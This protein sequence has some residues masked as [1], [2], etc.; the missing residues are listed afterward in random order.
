MNKYAPA[1]VQTAIAHLEAAVGADTTPSP[2]FKAAQWDPVVK[3]MT[4]GL[5]NAGVQASEF[6]VAQDH[7]VTNAAWRRGALSG[8]LGLLGLI[9]SG[10]LSVLI[11]RRIVRR[12]D[13]LQDSVETLANQELP[14]VVARLRRGE[15]VPVDQMASTTSDLGR[16][17]IGRVG[18]AFDAGRHTEAEAP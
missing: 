2:P 7:K 12:L 15:D 3:A 10:L 14:D 11:G 13:R 9:L 8:G 5:F 16:D 17:E 4:A 18:R 6:E 1:R